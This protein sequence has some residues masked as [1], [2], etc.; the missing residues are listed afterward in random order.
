MQTLQE[1]TCIFPI[2]WKRP[3]LRGQ[4]GLIQ[5]ALTEVIATTMEERAWVILVTHE[6]CLPGIYL[7]RL[8]SKEISQEPLNKERLVFFVISEALI[9]YPLVNVPDVLVAGHRQPFGRNVAPYQ[10]LRVRAWLEGVKRPC[11]RARK[12]LQ[13]C[14]AMREG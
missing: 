14:G 10:G 8:N 3:I 12:E 11:Q 4:H 6:F 2:I 7:S 13:R 5:L 1:P 9:S